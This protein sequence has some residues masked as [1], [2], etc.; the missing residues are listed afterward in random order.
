PCASSV[1]GVD[2]I[3][4]ASMAM[5]ASRFRCIAASGKCPP[6]GVMTP[7]G[8]GVSASASALCFGIEGEGFLAAELFRNAEFQELLRPCFLPLAGLLNHLFCCRGHL[9]RRSSQV[10]GA[11]RGRR[12]RRRRGRVLS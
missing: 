5:A 11:Q 9:S 1:L 4:V 2:T 6:K 3:R 10:A 7:F 8:T 12:R